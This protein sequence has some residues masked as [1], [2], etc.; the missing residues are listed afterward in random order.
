MI[1]ESIF[2]RVS[3]NHSKPITAEFLIIDGDDTPLLGRQTA[4]ELGLLKLCVDSASVTNILDQYADLC[5]G[6]GT[7]KD[8]EVTLHIVKE[9]APVARKHSRIPFHLH[10][11]VARE[12]ENLEKQLVIERVSGPTE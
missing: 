6:I 3:V 8:F 7:L 1:T 12:L 2:S 10:D 11:A 5:R 4:I 9:V